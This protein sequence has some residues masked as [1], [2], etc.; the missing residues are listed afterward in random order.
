MDIDRSEE[1]HETPAPTTP[2]KLRPLRRIGAA[3]WMAKHALRSDPL[4]KWKNPERRTQVV[5]VFV[6]ADGVFNVRYEFPPGAIVEVPRS[7]GVAFHKYTEQDGTR[8]VV[9]G[10]A[11]LLVREGQT[12]PVFEW[13][14]PTAEARRE[15]AHRAPRF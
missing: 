8:Y 11:P 14:I 15:P 13:I 7:H 9:G 6:G 5:D 12:E 4:E 1:G 10:L 3:E 2:G